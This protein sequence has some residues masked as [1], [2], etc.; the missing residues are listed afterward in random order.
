MSRTLAYYDRHAARFVEET[1]GVDISELH[2]RFLRHVPAGG[3]I[4]DAGCGSGRDSRAFVARGYRIV[5]F[6]ASAEIAQRASE[7]LGQG[8]AVR[9]FADVSELCSYDGIWA[10]ASLLHLPADDLPH[11]F[12]RL[13]RALKPGGAL[14][15]SFKH[16]DDERTDDERHFTDATESRLRAWIAGLDDIESSE[17]W[18]TPDQRPE[19]SESWLNAILRRR[20]APTSRL[21][22]GDAEHPFLPQ[23]CHAIAR[24]DEIDL[25]VS[26]VKTTGLRLLLPDL[27]DALGQSEVRSRPPARLRV[28]T[29]DY[30]DITDP[31]ALRLL[32]LLQEQGAHV[33][34]F[35]SAGRSFHMKAYLFAH[36]AEQRDVH[37]TAFIGSSNIS[38]QALTDGLEWN[39]RIDYPGDD[40]FI[41]ARAR[42]EE[43]FRDARTVALGDAWIDRYDARRVPPSRAIAPGSEES[44]PPPIPTPIQ[45]DALEALAATRREAYRRGLV[46]LATGLGKTWLAAFDAEQLGARRVLFVAH[47]E[48]ILNQAAETFVRIRPRA[49]VGFYM[50][51]IRDTQVDV[52]CASVQTLGRGTHLKRFSPQHFDYIVIDE[53]H[54]AAAP[55]YRRLLAHF[56]PQFL[57]GLTATPDRTDQSD[58]LSLCDDN[59]VFTRNLF[60]G[61]EAGLLAPF[62]YYGIWDESVDYREIPW[63]NGRFEPEQLS[64]KLATLARARH[65]LRHWRDRAQQRT[66]AFCV[67]IRHAKFMAAQFAHE[68]IAAAAVYAGSALARCEALE[69]LADGRLQVI[70]SV[71]LFNEGVD[72]PAI[73]T[74]L[75][76]R[77][78]ESKILFL[79]QLGRG[80]RRAEGKEKLVVLDFIGNHHSFLHK[81]QA[82]AQ[83]GASYKHLA[84]FAR[85]VE[86]RRLELPAGC[87]INYELELIDFLKS[88]DT[89]GIAKEY[90][91]L[92]DGL[93]RRPTLAEFY[94]CGANLGRMRK[95]YSSWF[96]LVGAMNDLDQDEAIVATAHRDFLREVETTAMTKSF[97]MVLLEA[98]QELDGWASAPSMEALAERSWQVLQRRR[99]LLADLPEAQFD[100]SDGRSKVWARY[101]RD[102]PVNAWIGGNQPAAAR[103]FFRIAGQRFEPGFD[104]E[105]AHRER[106]A[107]MVQELVDFRLAAYEVRRAAATPPDNVVPFKRATPDRTELPYFPNLC[108]ACGHFRTARADAEEHRSLGP[109]HGR[110]DPAR[111]FIARA[112]GN[113]MNG[114]KHPIRDGDYLLME[115]VS[116]ANAGSITG[117]TMAI[118]RQDQTGDDQYLLRVVTKHRDGS[119]VLVANNPD[120]ED[121]HVTPELADELRTVA[122]LKAVIDPLELAV[123]ESFMRE[124]I[125]PLFGENFNPGNWNSGHVALPARK[126]QVLL[127]TLNK[128]GKAEDHRYLDHWIDDHTFHWQSQN[129]TTPESKRGREIIEHEK[130]G[131]SLHLFVRESKLAGGKAA[132]FVY[133]GPVR[134]RSHSGSGPMS[135]VFEVGG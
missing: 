8:V 6:D 19:R 129:S 118:E 56:V 101:W 116:P 45:V 117:T 46:V 121:I 20:P 41:E 108:I 16:G 123:G 90:Q 109:G 9:S 122:R 79:Q 64:N 27:H 13:W 52:L 53:F 105:P 111:H 61:I 115:L 114:G 40:G 98:F 89:D 96:G 100:A 14:Y 30:L 34:V 65:A 120:Y 51:Q 74:V 71:D 57:L 24:A 104:V 32:M 75:M 10:C 59:L 87:F 110:L 72:L 62:H 132:P 99:P 68:G 92:K 44:E 1:I 54:H 102:N 7:V 60:A 70:F 18:V 12:E 36:F 38:R 88:L 86:T 39:Y 95:E 94:R 25:A 42:F 43:L 22:T 84:E 107:A 37:G 67:S 85:K 48:E 130:R 126:A 93:G 80:L 69:R 127:V 15:V 47:R 28:L 29:S 33:R 63:R 112:S 83:V 91:A 50:G 76:L 73:D 125:P 78:T 23:L 106:F 5:A 81:P 35:E 135:V 3:L 11:A 128:Q 66:L 2:A 26:F 77:P 49:R 124:D 113:S 31:E 131:I 133:Y 4:L 134:Y 82:L 17:C 21:I 119:Y 58:I 103:K 55:T 97:K